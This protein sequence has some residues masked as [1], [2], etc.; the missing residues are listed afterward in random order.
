MLPPLRSNVAIDFAAAVVFARIVN[1]TSGRRAG[2]SAI[3][4]KP[5]VVCEFGGGWHE[6]VNNAVAL[7]KSNVRDIVNVNALVA[8]GN[9]NSFGRSLRSLR[10]R[11]RPNPRRVVTLE[12]R[13]RNLFATVPAATIRSLLLSAS[14]VATAVYLVAP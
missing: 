5:T 14:K 9:V 7:R 2:I 12:L 11:T 10:P 4:A 13:F 1:K 6:S 8:L 3:V